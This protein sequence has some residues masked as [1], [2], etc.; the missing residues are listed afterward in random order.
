MSVGIVCV[1]DGLGRP[2]NLGQRSPMVMRSDAVSTECTVT[3]ASR[4]RHR[5]RQRAAELDFEIV[6]MTRQG[7]SEIDR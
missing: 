4:R 2:G 5:Q 3:D 6:K 7:G 1:V